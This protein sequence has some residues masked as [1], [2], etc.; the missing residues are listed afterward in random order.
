M[1]KKK[2]KSSSSQAAEP[3]PPPPIDQDDSELL[4]ELLAHL[5]SN[6][7]SQESKV[8]AAN[9]IQDVEKAHSPPT[10]E[11][12]SNKKSGSRAKFEARKVKQTFLRWSMTVLICSFS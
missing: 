11:S 7:V 9:M 6:N 5:D 1:A 2:S 10:V 3:V 4:D 12:E 8:E